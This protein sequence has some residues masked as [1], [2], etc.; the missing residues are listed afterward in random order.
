MARLRSREFVDRWFPWAFAAVVSLVFFVVSW[1]R[2][3]TLAAGFDVAYFKQAAWQLSHGQG[4]FLSVRGVHLFADHAYFVMY[5]IGWLSRLVPVTPLLLGLQAAG[6]GFA[7]VPLYRI[8][9]GMAGLPPA[10]SALVLG[11]YALH[12]AIQN[13]NIFEF[14]PE[15]VTAPLALLGAVWFGHRNRWVACGVCVA[16]VLLTREDYVFVVAGLALIHLLGGRRRPAVAMLGAAAVWFV[17][18]GALMAQFPGATEIRATRLAPYGTSALGAAGFLGRHP[19]LLWHQLTRPENFDVLIGLLGPVLFLPLL[20][21]VWL[22]PAAGLELV[23]MLSNVAPAHTIRF[24]Y[25]L[26]PGVAVVLA[27]A[28]ALGRLRAGW[29]PPVTGR[30][31][32]PDR[33]LLVPVL[34]AALLFSL[35]AS[36]MSALAHPW[37]WARRDSVDR[38]RLAAA[39]VPAPDASVAASASILPLVAAR[40]SA[41]FFPAPFA[42]YAGRLHPPDPVPLADRIASVRYLLI[43][44][45]TI[46]TELHAD[47]IPD[48]LHRLTADGT[49]EQLWD[50]HGVQVWRRAGGPGP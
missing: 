35:H 12:P 23:Y 16:I 15:T 10:T 49:F 18:V 39:H 7:A 27:A 11:V 28:V 42:A 13:A 32:P 38:A 40:R 3:Y 17:V 14:H 1:L 9:R 36:S 43:D 44:T 47:M 19:R 45:T 4:G 26:M 20:A 30:A 48:V 33:T 46:P 21:P 34:G 2:A 37:Q 50:D 24:Q 5:P 6:L 31:R 25:T 8:C 22:L 41:Y 29:G